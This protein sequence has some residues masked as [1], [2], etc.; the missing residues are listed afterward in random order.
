MDVR[1]LLWGASPWW[2]L[3]CLLA[4]LLYAGLLYSRTPTL[5]SRTT[6]WGLFALR[7]VLASLVCLLL[8]EPFLKQ[9]T[10]HVEEPVYLV[11]IDNSLSVPEGGGVTEALLKETIGRLQQELGDKGRIELRTLEGTI[12]QTDSLRFDS[13]TT[14]LSNLLSG[15]RSDYENRNLAGVV[16]LSDGIYN[17][18]ISPAFVPYP[19]PVY[20]LGLGDTL[21][22]TDVN[23]KNLYYN[24]V[25]YQGNQFRVRAE[26]TQNGYENQPL[27]LTV[28]RGNRVLQQK[29]LRFAQG[30]S[31]LEEEIVLD[32]DEAGLQHYVFEVNG[33]SN[34]Y[35][36][37]NNTRHA[38]IE[39]IE[40]REKIL[41]VANSPH[42]DI[43]AFRR[44]IE[45]NKNYQSFLYIPGISE[46]QE[47]NYDL[48]ILHGLPGGRNI[49]QMDQILKN[50]RARWYI[51]SNQTDLRAFNQQ[52]ELVQ[53]QSL[54][55]EFDEVFPIL[56]GNFDLFT[57][58][59]DYR[60]N[61]AAYP[62]VQVP[63]GRIQ[64]AGWGR[65]LLQQRIGRVDTDKPLLVIGVQEE[66]KTAVM[67]GEGMWQ[68]R[69][70]EFA[71]T[72]DFKAFDELVLKTVQ[73]LSARDDRRR[74]KVYPLEE[75]VLDTEGVT[76][77]TEVYNQ[78]YERIWGQPVNLLITDESGKQFRYSYQN[79][80]N[81]PR[82]TVQ[83]L[84]AG[85]YQYRASTELNGETH[86]A[87]GRFSVQ[88]LQ[89]E[90]LE[91][92][93]NHNLLR[94]ISE[95]TG[96]RYYHYQQEENLIQELKELEAKNVITADEAYESVL[97][98]EW[99]L[100]L[101]LL[102]ISAEWFVRKYNGG[103]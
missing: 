96:G 43:T 67:L 62:P 13:Q 12:P 21:P 77:E 8:L 64:T 3:V 39:V 73:L 92:T 20:S 75:E 51:V 101:I 45:K 53:I 6:N 76:F 58:S 103:Y 30:A 19:F 79:T 60:R 49:P 22:K 56:N 31:L 10:R 11:A 23:L 27:T 48:V 55:R 87:T 83:N 28:R 85:V 47:E 97:N 24:K 40:G 82:Y 98:L 50:A 35:T 81:N 71:A 61:I 68:W 25:A 54:Q 59:G 66:K 80:R 14:N 95:K 102:L 70:Q 99:L 37:K 93:A 15:V 89:L 57:Y 44:A 36:Q 86:T 38:Y 33:A 2:I 91:L 9:L 52:Q 63:F 74:F 84:P 26:I 7:F 32:A 41:I 46:Y 18:G 69:L 100:V 90:S 17:Q 4:G 34:E 16:L 5:W 94:T 29:S 65:M 1:Q 78:A 88:N 72:E 42:P